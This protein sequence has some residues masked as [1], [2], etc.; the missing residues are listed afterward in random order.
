[1]LDMIRY[2]REVKES[3]QSNQ[4][5]SAPKTSITR[6]CNVTFDRPGTKSALVNNES[7]TDSSQSLHS[8]LTG[9]V[10]RISR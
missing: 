7:I 10:V 3:V 4:S 5:S 8:N 6:C 9:R 1:M 2:S